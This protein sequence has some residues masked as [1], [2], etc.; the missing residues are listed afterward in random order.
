MM[1]YLVIEWING[2][3]DWQA[4]AQ[5]ASDFH[6][7]EWAKTNATDHGYGVEVWDVQ[8]E[9]RTIWERTDA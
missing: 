3:T 2:R 5:F 4:V 8:N 9:S 7:I 1:R 6:A